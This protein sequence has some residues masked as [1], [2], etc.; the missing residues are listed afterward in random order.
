MLLSMNT[1][2]LYLGTA[3]GAA[4]GGFVAPLMGFS[5][6]P[7]AGVPLLTLAL[8]LLAREPGLAQNSAALGGPASSS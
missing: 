4:L 3:A 5:T 8:L 2:L 7:W 6:L 1:S